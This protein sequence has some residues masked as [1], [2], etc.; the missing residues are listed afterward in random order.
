MLNCSFAC[1]TNSS[2]LF[3]S[4]FCAASI[5]LSLS[6][7]VRVVS[8]LTFCS[9]STSILFLLAIIE[10]SRVFSFNF[11][12]CF[13]RSRAFS[14]TSVNDTPVPLIALFIFSA[15]LLKSPLNS[16]T[17]AVVPV[18]IRFSN[19]LNKPFNPAVACAIMSVTGFS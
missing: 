4:S 3:L 14:K 2:V 11:C 16:L 10:Y 17:I 8:S 6:D 5:A 9:F 13:S 12:C 18:K 7:N 19:S 1:L 15:A